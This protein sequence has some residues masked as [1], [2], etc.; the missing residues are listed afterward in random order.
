MRPKNFILIAALAM[1]VSAVTGQSA[2]L[3]T[4]SSPIAGRWQTV[5]TCQGVVVDLQKMGLR[6]VAPVVVGDYFP[7]QTPQALAKKKTICQGARPQIHAHFF[8]SDGKFGSIDQHGQQVDDGLYKVSG[9]TITIGN[10]DVKGSFRFRIQGRTLML[11]PLLTSAL[12][13][14]ALADPLNFHPAGWMV[15]VAYPG[16]AWQRVACGK[17]C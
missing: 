11:T 10:S 6:A 4:T 2:V 9:S 5:R 12:K 3:R 13:Q 1:M 8:T 17:W 16:H 7:G 15:A 14:G